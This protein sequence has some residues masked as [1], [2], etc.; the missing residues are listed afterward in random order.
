MTGP[1]PKIMRVAKPVSRQGDPFSRSAV[2]IIIPYHGH[3]QNVATLVESILRITQ[4]NP[5]Q[6][7]L[8]DDAS[9]NEHESR[10]FGEEFTKLIPDVRESIPQ[11]IWTRNKEQLGFAAS[12]KQGYDLTAQQKVIAPW[13]VFLHSDCKVIDP[14][15]MI[16]MGRSL[17]SGKS[18][19]VKMVS[20][21]SN[22]PGEGLHPA[23]RGERDDEIRKGSDV[24]LEDGFIPLYCAMC[25]RDLFNH[26]GGFI[27]SYPY[28]MYEDEE[29]A[30]RM[31][32]H[33]YKQAISVKSWIS[34]EGGV[35]INPL[36]TNS[37]V[38]KAMEEN[39]N[40]C[41]SDMRSLL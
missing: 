3:F 8:V 41:I 11:I 2:S 28:A 37:K 34:H 27:K 25:H 36:C 31:K 35:T 39:R 33:R 7:C 17:L 26:I 24:I 10:L 6:I 15:W 18:S 20:A 12:L 29:L 4:S 1:T 21:R 30:F 5:Y 23:L 22:N 16:E 13:V 40:R 14:A 32:K 38:R 19:G 9:P